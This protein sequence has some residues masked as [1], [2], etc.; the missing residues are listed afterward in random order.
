MVATFVPDVA[1]S[2]PECVLSAVAAA[3]AP[4]T[5]GLLPFKLASTT[6][7]QFAFERAPTYVTT[8]SVACGSTLVAGGTLA[9]VIDLEEYTVDTVPYFKCVIFDM[10]SRI[11]ESYQAAAALPTSE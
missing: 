2:A 1:C 6:D 8:V 11:P 3:M 9:L 7:S 4:D 10:V 5:Q